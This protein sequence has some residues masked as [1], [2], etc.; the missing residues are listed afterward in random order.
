MFEQMRSIKFSGAAFNE[1]T[2]FNLFPDDNSR[3]A[4]VYGRNGTGKSTVARA[5]SKIKGEENSDIISALLV[6]SQNNVIPT[7]DEISSRVHVFSD[8]YVQTNVRLKEDGLNTIVMFGSQGNL[9]DQIAF[10]QN[11]YNAKE[12]ERARQ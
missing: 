12:D 11:E 6:N 7:S 2:T 8:E 3:L 4:L 5:F 9:D 10:A 1:E